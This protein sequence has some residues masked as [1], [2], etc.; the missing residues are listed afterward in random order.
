MAH[1]K[2]H[3]RNTRQPLFDVLMI[4][5]AWAKIQAF[6]VIKL[7]KNIL[8]HDERRWMELMMMIMTPETQKVLRVF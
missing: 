7:Y 4:F 8:N 3:Q 1:A 2:I 6:R 5:S